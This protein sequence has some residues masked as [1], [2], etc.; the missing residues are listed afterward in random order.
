M[1]KNKKLAWTILF[2]V[3]LVFLLGFFSSNKTILGNH[4]FSKVFYDKNGIIL[5]IT[6]SND[7]KYR[8]Y[9]PLDDISEVFQD[10]VL[11]YED[12]YFYY[13]PGFNPVSLV[14]A[15]YKSYISKESYVGASTITMQLARKLYDIDSRT[16]SGKIWQIINAIKLEIFYSKDEI[17]EAY[18]NLT[19][20]GYNIEGIG[21]AS[22]I[23][24][25]K[26]PRDLAM[27]RALNLITIPQNPNK[28]VVKNDKNE[29]AKLHVFKQLVEK[30]PQYKD[31][32]NLVK[33]ALKLKRHLHLYAPHFTD[34]LDLK[35]LYKKN[36]HTTLDLKKQLL[37]ENITKSYIKRH[38]ELG[39][40]NAAILLLNWKNME[41]ES[42]I[43]SKNYF[44]NSI[45]GQVNGVESKR[46]PGSSFKPFIYALALQEG[47]IHPMSLMKDSPVRYS[48]YSPSNFD[49]IFV[50]PILA[51]DA[52][53]YSRNVP[54]VN[55]MLQLQ[56]K[57]FHDLLQ[58]A[59]I[60]NLKSE[61]YYGLALA[62]GAFEVS[63]SESAKL[64]AMLRNYGKM[65]DIKY[66]KDDESKS[67]QS[68][69][70]EAAF[71]TLDILSKNP[72]PSK[73]NQAFITK[74]PNYESY[75]KTGTSYAFK[76]AW[77]VGVFGP[78]VLAVW[79]GNFDAT[80]NNA[81]VGRKIAAPL[82]FEI[83]D[84]LAKRQDDFSGDYM[85]SSN[86]NLTKVDLCQDTGDLPGAFCPNLVESWFIPGVSTIK[87]SSIYRKVFI[88]KKTGLR[89][90][91]HDPKTTYSKIYEFWDSDIKEMFESA[92][93]YKKSPPE[94]MPECSL[95]ETSTF[96][97]SP[98]IFLPVSKVL[99][100][101][102]KDSGEDKIPLK[103]NVD[104]DVKKVFWFIDNQFVGSSD[105]SQTIYWQNPR[106]GNFS[107]QVVDELG[108]SST[109]EIS[110]VLKPN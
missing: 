85:G 93:I 104:H 80:G 57:S 74:L 56:Q 110:V 30:Y 6:L 50:G 61:E 36:F 108:R 40:N 79:V 67:K 22:M 9:T 19:P 27:I 95:V 86:L 4:S 37:L 71:L 10:A 91:Y 34:H 68:I 83:A 82:F 44:D 106:S 41:I 77:S 15:F 13:H 62:L 58:E 35:Y 21:A 31:K 96:G 17:L 11:T 66:L 55:L 75:W 89:A 47:I 76:D 7:E 24:F 72:R 45:S 25:K 92:G 29:H 18:L 107:V 39:V 33:I 46:S 81:F 1:T 43:G 65:Q 16:I 14:Q 5:R 103:A 32:E 78:Y 3:F 52:L 109:R 97:K 28:R 20:Y 42:Y 54:A 2:M 90:C 51:K 63:M 60:S 84:N 87:T 8:I 99:Y 100:V 23:Y 48:S 94:F 101:I 70:K 64:Y 98:Q 53:I 105:G 38:Q 88:D 12:K 69:S 73:I 26:H 59:Q 102:D 49:K